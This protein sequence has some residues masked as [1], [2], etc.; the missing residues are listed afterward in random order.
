MAADSQGEEKNI[1]QEEIVDVIIMLREL[2]PHM[3]MMKQ[4]E[5]DLVNNLIQKFRLYGDKMRVTE[6]Q[7]NCLLDITEKLHIKIAR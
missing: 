6:K 1:D 2:H 5:I 4:F 3:I 7:F